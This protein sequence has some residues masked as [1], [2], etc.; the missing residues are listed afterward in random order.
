MKLQLMQSLKSVLK[1]KGT[2]FL[3]NI[4][5]NQDKFNNWYVDDNALNQ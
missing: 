4:I 5:L 2:Y 3:D 1:I